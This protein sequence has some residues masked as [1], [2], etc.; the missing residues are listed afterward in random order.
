MHCSSVMVGLPDPRVT[1]QVLEMG[2]L[3]QARKTTC[4]SSASRLALPVVDER[5]ITGDIDA[6]VL[7]S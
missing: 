3:Q 2:T 7:G 5:W 6:D 1:V 4:N